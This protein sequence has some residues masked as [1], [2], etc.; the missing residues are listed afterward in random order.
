[1]SSL[2][3]CNN[4][5]RAT[6]AHLSLSCALTTLVVFSSTTLMPAKEYTC[7]EEVGGTA[8]QITR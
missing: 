6:G 7:S 1:M 8:G 5:S 3:C 4:V 2:A